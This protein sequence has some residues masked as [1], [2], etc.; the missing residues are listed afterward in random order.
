MITHLLNSLLIG[1]LVADMM[2]R[3]FPEE[4]RKYFM[5]FSFNCIYLFSKFQIFTF[6]IYNAS[7]KLIES[8][9]TSLKI[10][11]EI[12]SLI[13]NILSQINN[14]NNK[15]KI[16]YVKCGVLY[17][18]L[19]DNCD[20]IISNNTNEGCV[21][22]KIFYENNNLNSDHELSNIRFMLLEFKVGENIAHKIDLKTEYYNYY[23]IGNKFTKDFFQFYIHYHLNVNDPINN[24]DKCS[25]KLLD[26]DVNKIELNFTDK[27]E[28]IM[29][30]KNGYQLL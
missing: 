2:E 29:L 4:S 9:Q 28:S 7:N 10:K 20:F 22:K 14:N 8:N 19:V 16:Q 18:Y 27:N 25:I 1:L 15:S 30:E 3:R 17:D 13:N 26:H 12:I 11:N 5:E 21:T 6:K 23:V 24:N